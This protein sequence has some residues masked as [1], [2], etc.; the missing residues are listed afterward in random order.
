MDLYRCHRLAHNEIQKFY[1]APQSQDSLTSISKMIFFS[2]LL[3][4]KNVSVPFLHLTTALLA[5]FLNAAG[6]AVSATDYPFSIESIQI[7]NG[8]Q[9][10]AHNKGPAPISAVVS[11]VESQ[12]LASNQH[13][14]IINV[15]PPH[16][17]LTIGVV[18]PSNPTSGY[19]FKTSVAY[20]L[21]VIGTQHDPNTLYRMPYLDG[22]TFTIGQAPGGIITTHTTP[23]SQFAIDFPMP[24]GTLVLA[25]RGGVVVDV[26]DSHTEGGKDARLLTQANDVKILHSD[27]T[28]ATYAH[29]MPSGVAVKIGQ[30]IKAGEIIGYSGSTGYSS[31]PHLHFAVSKVVEINGVLSELSVPT[32]FY[33]G[34]PIVAFEPQAGL[35]VTANYI[36]AIDPLRLD[37]TNIVATT[38]KTQPT[39][40]G[41]FDNLQNGNTPN[42]Q[43]VRNSNNIQTVSLGALIISLLICL[44]AVLLLGFHKLNEEKRRRQLLLDEFRRSSES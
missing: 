9:I 2:G 8:H 23:E 20:R 43:Q 11:I 24:V 33:V 31:G 26:E 17:D 28:I 10:V 42:Q 5:V 18:F 13:W 38:A 37:Q 7:R 25:A 16:S 15:V 34:K 1:D 4:S 41:Q 22:R 3:N 27:G 21:G 40:V 14:P 39:V 44:L 19:S 32:T 29:L 12:N 30:E 6:P 36:S 35:R